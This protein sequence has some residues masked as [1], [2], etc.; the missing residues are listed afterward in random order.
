MSVTGEAILAGGLLGS[1]FMSGVG[2]IDESCTGTIIDVAGYQMKHAD[3]QKQ[4]L[5]VDRTSS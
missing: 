1:R 2:V 4:V 5:L 3:L